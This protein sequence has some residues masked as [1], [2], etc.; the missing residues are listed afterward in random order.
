MLTGFKFIGE[1]IKEYEATNE[2]TFI[3]G[4]EESFGYLEGTHARDKD[5]VVACMLL[6]ETAC[7]YASQG[8]NL[9]EGLECIYKKY[10]YNMELLTSSGPEISETGLKYVHNDTCYPALLVIGQMIDA[11]KS[12]K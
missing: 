3:F 4:F 10:G 5:A 12:G 8:M 6:A 11:L 2:H 1:K 9:L 7:D